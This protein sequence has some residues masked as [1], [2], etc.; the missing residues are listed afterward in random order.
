MGFAAPM[1]GAG[2]AILLILPADA[3]RH[4]HPAG[5]SGGGL[6]LFA[7]RHQPGNDDDDH[8]GAVVCRR[9]RGGR[10]A[11]GSFRLDTV[12]NGSVYARG[13]FR[14]SGLIMLVVMLLSFQ[15]FVQTGAV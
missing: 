11:D 12:L 1:N 3:V 8:A 13:G 14:W 6:D 7:A 9:H 4:L 15:A 2:D 5:G 10:G